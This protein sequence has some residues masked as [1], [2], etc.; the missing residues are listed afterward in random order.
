MTE[1]KLTP[2]VGDRVLFREADVAKTYIGIVLNED[3]TRLL[4]EPIFRV[5]IDG[6]KGKPGHNGVLYAK[7]SELT[8]VD[9]EP[10]EWPRGW[11]RHSKR[12]AFVKVVNEALIMS[13][14]MIDKIVTDGPQI[15]R[16]WPEL[17]GDS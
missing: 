6:L 1:K 3:R 12:L 7:E 9:R 11:E 17:M 16:D 5:A 4:P 2:R 10:K 13:R 14:E 8:V 15:L